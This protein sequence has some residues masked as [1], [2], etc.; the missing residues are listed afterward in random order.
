V[1]LALG[2]AQFGL[3]YGIANAT[4]QVSRDEAATIL[5]L[6]SKAGIDTID[7]AMAYGDSESRL[8]SIGVSGFRVVSKLPALPEDISDVSG[9][10]AGAVLASLQRL[11]VDCLYGLLLHRPDQ[12]L[13][14][15]G[16]VIFAALQ[17]MKTQG[18]VRKIGVSIYEPAELDLLASRFTF[19]LVQAPFS[20]LD[21]RLLE[22]GW[23]SRL[24]TAGTEVHV[25]SVFL[26]GLLLLPASRRPATIAPWAPVLRAYDDWVT[27]SGVT[28]TEACLSYA[29]AQPAIQRVV[30]GV[31][32][33]AQ[34]EQLLVASRR[35]AVPVPADVRCEDVDLL[36]PAR[37]ATP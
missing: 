34:L 14:A 28:A 7:T 30:V 11:D 20:V 18:L 37:W 13:G 32:S 4:G 19:D 21:R 10:I 1:K 15:D 27:R 31:D 25:R 23:L 12:L 17:N 16:E 24:A 22:S 3:R 5:Q 36:N 2:T 33:A 26:Q 8:G 9:W 6:A 29:L 35:A